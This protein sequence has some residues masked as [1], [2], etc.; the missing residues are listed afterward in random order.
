[1]PFYTW[2]ESMS[3]GVALLDSDHKALIET[4]NRL[5]DA[6]EDGDEPQVLDGIFDG[7]VAYIEY[8]FAREER[9][10][11][12]CGYP[13]ATEH[14]AEHL[15]FAQNMRYNRDRYFRG[16]E[17]G[18]GRELLDYLKDWLTHHILIDDMAYRPY[19]EGNPSTD[20]V[21][22]ALGPGLWERDG[23]GRRRW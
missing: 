7:L 3:V 17:A 9:I 2:S 16:E 22:E 20:R 23:F 4:I 18:V 13:T 15:R 10:M 1:M 19:A 21:A 12:V 5:H 11:E 8:H 14:A 6:V